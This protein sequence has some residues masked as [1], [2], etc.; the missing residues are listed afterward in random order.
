VSAPLLESLEIDR[1]RFPDIYEERAARYRL[2]PYRLKLSYT[3][4]G[5]S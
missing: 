1:L 4:S 5:C 3:W 2:E